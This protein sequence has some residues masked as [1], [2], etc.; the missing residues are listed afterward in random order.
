ME[1]TFVT[2]LIVF[3][4]V[5]YMYCVVFWFLSFT[6]FFLYLYF[7]TLC[8]VLSGGLPLLPLCLPNKPSRNSSEQILWLTFRRKSQQ[9]D[10]EIFT[11]ALID[12]ASLLTT[13]HVQQLQA[14]D[15]NHNYDQWLLMINDSQWLLIMMMITD[16]KTWRI[17][18][19]WPAMTE[20][21][22]M[23]CCFEWGAN[24][25]R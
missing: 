6:A 7:S 15:D 16:G 25:W 14:N 2:A 21:T 1:P 19:C 22:K 17:C 24:T 11:F 3:V 5:Y 13:V 23:R 9:N 4:F 20:G 10:S 8:W 18:S 12:K